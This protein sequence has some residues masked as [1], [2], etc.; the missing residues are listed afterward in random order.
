MSSY[1]GYHGT[2]KLQ[3]DADIGVE[4][5][6]LENAARLTYVDW[7][8]SQGGTDRTLKVYGGGRMSLQ[9]S[10]DIDEA[11]KGFG[12][13]L[14]E[15]AVIQTEWENERGKLIVAVDKKARLKARSTDTLK[16]ITALLPHLDRACTLALIGK[17]NSRIGH[18]CPMAEID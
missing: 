9:Q 2:L 11:L 1:A 15:P 18:G 17:C 4:L 16:E 6:A 5:Q 7:T 14:S 13:H 12:K 8:L 10:N 3:D